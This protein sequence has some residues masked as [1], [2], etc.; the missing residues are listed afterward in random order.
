MM[1]LLAPAGD[2]SSLEAALAAGAGAVYFGLT[3]LNAR[4]RARNFQQDEFARAVAAVHARGARAYLTLNVD[5]G[6]RELGQAAKILHWA[7]Q[8]GADAVLVRDPAL[9]ALRPEFPELEFHFSTQ[10][11]MANSADVAAAGELGAGRVVLARELTLAEIAAA[12]AVPGVKTEVFVQGALCFSVSG[13]CLLSSWIG[14]RSGNRGECTSPCR[15]PWTIAGQSRGTPLSMRDLSAIDRLA[16]LRRCGVAALKIEGR[17]K[18]AQWVGRAVD[19]YRRALAGENPDNLHE[20]IERLGTYAGRTMT[21]G[22]LDGLR[23]NLTGESGRPAG[24]IAAGVP[25]VAAGLLTEPPAWAAEPSET[26]VRQ[27]VGGAHPADADSLIPTD[28]DSLIPDSSSPVAPP[29][30]DLEIRITPGGIVFRCDCGGYRQQWTVPKTVVRRAHKAVSVGQVFA[31]LGREPVQGCRLGRGTSDELEFLM[32]PR[33]V[34]AL[35]ARISAVVHRARKPWEQPLQVELPEP[36]R[37]VLAPD[38]PDPANTRSL[39]DR[40]DRARLEPAALEAFLRSVEVEGVIL[41]GL[42]K[43]SLP[44]AL[45]ACRGAEIVAA[46]PAVFFEQDIP[47]IQALLR[48]CRAAEVAVEVNSWGGWRLARQAGVRIEAGPG[49]PVLNAV[50]ARF[51][52]RCGASCVTLSPEG[53]RRQWEAISAQCPVP[54]SLVVFGRPPLLCTRVRLPEPQML[55]QEFE[56]RRGTRLVPRL[57]RGLWVFRPQAPLDLRGLANP[58]I[59]VRHLVVDLVGSPGALEEWY[60][61][62]YPGDQ[63]SLFHF[64][65]DRG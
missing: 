63:R 48:E 5:L 51:L 62:P 59:R 8:C 13:R 34:N 56:D 16:E 14:G 4:R 40:P 58:K 17:L 42:S 19:L 41:E 21:S 22:Y 52:A 11:C 38:R 33:A 43:Q 26:G 27:L 29:T 12:S 54:C 9:L 23:D 65:Y 61:A 20:E 24:E 2:P 36:V 37:K 45:R 15:L 35:M 18:N 64:N 28:A 30:Y 47:A 57:E 25:T 10:T 55:H 3:A 49:L 60:D 1:E 46:L 6:Q 44:K 7:C 53:N 31:L 39:G 32:V 50:A